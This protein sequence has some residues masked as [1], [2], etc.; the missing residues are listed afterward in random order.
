MLQ[1]HNTT[2]F[3]A[4]MALFPN[5]DAIDTLYLIVKATFDISRDLTLSDEQAK[6]IDADVYWTEAG[7]SSVKYASDMHIGKPSTDI[8]MLGHACAPNK[9]EVTQLDVAL[10]VGAVSKTVR[11]YG[12]R[13]WKDGRRARKL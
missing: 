11:V 12:D 3:A 5:E 7:K 1:L 2:P 4:S 8:I 6:P 10:S 9:Q 13:Q